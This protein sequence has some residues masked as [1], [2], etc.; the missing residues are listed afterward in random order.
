M[1]RNYKTEA[2]I[3]SRK[4]YSEA[5]R[6]LTLYSKNFGKIYTI[7]KG[8]RRPSSR[9]RGSLEIFSHITF[10]ASRGKSLD[11]MTEVETVDNFDEVRSDLKKVSVAYFFVETIK[12][13]NGYCEKGVDLDMYKKPEYLIPFKKPP[14]YAFWLQN[15]AN[16]TH[17]GIVI[18]ENMEMVREDDRK[19]I[20]NLFAVG[21]NA[22]AMDGGMRWGPVSGYMAGIAAAKY[23]GLGPGLD[24]S[25]LG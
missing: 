10:S 23:M 19:G 15:F 24:R 21:D 20:P 1:S 14:Y 7:A 11:I 3:L 2:I 6:I 25:S 16:T 22:Q 13:Y 5:D 4:N 8:I 12:K 9:K 17:N 18:N